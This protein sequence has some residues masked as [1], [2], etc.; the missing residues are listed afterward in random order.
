MN[1]YEIEQ[2][3][4]SCVDMESGEVIDFEKLDALTMERDQKIENIALWVKNLEADAKAYKEEKDNFAQKQ[5][6]AE[7]KAKSL[8]EYLSRFLDGTAYKS[9]K[10]NVSFRTS[11]AVDVFDISALMTMDDCDNYLKY[12]EPEPDKTAIK[13]AIASGVNVPGCQI[14]ENQNIQ[15]K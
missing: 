7:N 13:N 15:I 1:L 10:V 4:M 12:K 2:E 14:V 8:K 9:T 5:K 11:K 6:S 3:I